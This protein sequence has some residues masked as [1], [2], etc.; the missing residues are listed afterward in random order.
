MTVSCVSKK[1]HHQDHEAITT[2]PPEFL[3]SLLALHQPT[4]YDREFNDNENKDRNMKTRPNAQYDARI[5]Y[6]C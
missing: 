4:M 6:D 5:R 2:Q 1:K 3:V